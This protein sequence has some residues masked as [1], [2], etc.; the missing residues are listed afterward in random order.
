MSNDKI[1][2][3]PPSSPRPSSPPPPPPPPPRMTRDS[4]GHAINRPEKK[5][6]Q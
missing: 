3:P 5:D 6:G 2:N 1:N 4:N